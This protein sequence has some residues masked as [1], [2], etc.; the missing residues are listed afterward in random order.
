[1]AEMMCDRDIGRWQR[2]G[3]TKTFRWAVFW[4]LTCL[5]L[6]AFACAALVHDTMSGGRLH[7][8]SMPKPGSKSRSCVAWQ[9]RR[10]YPPRSQHLAPLPSSARRRAWARLPCRARTMRRRVSVLPPPRA[11][12]LRAL[13][14]SCMLS[15]SWPTSPQPLQHHEPVSTM[16]SMCRTAREDSGTVVHMSTHKSSLTRHRS[17]RKKSNR[18]MNA[19]WARRCSY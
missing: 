3:A 14:R 9:A 10:S 5:L 17:M 6:S 1:M 4:R 8:A 19:H 15:E 2:W 7:P 12:T 16:R 13:L 18:S 11:R